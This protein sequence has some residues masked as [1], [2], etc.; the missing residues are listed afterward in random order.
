MLQPLIS[1]KDAPERQ[2]GT[3]CKNGCQQEL[4]HVDQQQ[5]LDYYNEEKGYKKEVSM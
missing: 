1:Y 3:E 2:L 4:Y 5:K